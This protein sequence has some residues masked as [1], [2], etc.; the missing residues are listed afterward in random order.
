MNDQGGIWI[1]LGGASVNALAL[2]TSQEEHLLFSLRCASAL[3]GTILGILSISHETI[4]RLLLEDRRLGGGYYKLLRSKGRKQR[5]KRYRSRDSRGRLP[6]KRMIDERPASVESR[7][8]FGHWEIDTVM[9]KYGTRACILTLVERKTGYVLIGK[10]KNRSVEQ[11]NQRLL[12]LMRSEGDVFKS[13]R[14]PMELRAV[15]GNRSQS[16]S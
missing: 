11:T 2:L 14:I 1:A 8:H 4:Y 15:V 3:V 7:R 16:A 6:G 9:G 13:I 10:L 5:R 12:K